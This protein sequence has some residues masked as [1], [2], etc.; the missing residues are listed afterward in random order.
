MK[1]L[2]KY[3]I[4]DFF[5]YGN[6]TLLRNIYLWQK[7]FEKVSEND[8]LNKRCFPCE[9]LGSQ[10][11]FVLGE[12]SKSRLLFLSVF[13]DK[14]S[15]LLGSHLY[16]WYILPQTYAFLTFFKLPFIFSGG[17]PRPCWKSSRVP[18]TGFKGSW[19]TGFPGPV[20]FKFPFVFR[21]RPAA[22]LCWKVPGFPFSFLFI[23][24]LLD[25]RRVCHFVFC[26]FRCVRYFMFCLSLDVC[27]VSCSVR[28]GSC[29]LF[30]VPFDL[31]CLS[32]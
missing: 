26:S 23:F 29:V 2:L 21:W 12:A 28:L 17:R 16:T 15:F 7:L 10:M 5:P 25:F 24:V 6:C 18:G 9:I 30:N 13:P 14:H 32:C 20:P 27:A 8:I 31:R 4:W 19:V 3:L 1:D 11:W 22:A